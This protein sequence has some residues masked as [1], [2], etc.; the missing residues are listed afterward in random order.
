MLYKWTALYRPEDGYLLGELAMLSYNQFSFTITNNN[1]SFY[2]NS[3]AFIVGTRYDF[4][5]PIG[6]N[7]IPHFDP[8]DIL[9]EI[10]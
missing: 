10:L 5:C 3:T 6:E 7:F 9:K 1:N 8:N 2:R 4:M